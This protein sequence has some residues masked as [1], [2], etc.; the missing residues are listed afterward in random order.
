MSGV[1]YSPTGQGGKFMLEMA[2]RGAAPAFENAWR[3]GMCIQVIASPAE[4]DVDPDAE[5]T[6][7]VKVKHKIEGNDLD[8]PV[9]AKMSS[10]PKSIDPSGQKQKSPATFK[11]KAGPQSGDHGVVSFDSV[12]NRGI[13]GASGNYTVGGGWVISGTGTSNEN[14]QSGVVANNL[15]VSIKDLKVKAE[16]DGALTGTGSMTLSGQV[17]AGGLCKGQLDQTLP[18]TAKGTLVGSSSDGTLKLTLVTPAQPGVMVTMTCQLPGVAYDQAVSAEGYADRYGE[19]LGQI[20]LPAGGGTK[21]ASKTTSFG[22]V[23]DVA[24]S[25]S[26]TVVKAKK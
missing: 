12:S 4:E 3:S 7:T 17:T 14:F 18:I 21:T 6:V 8:K 23:M 26:F 10:G 13:G 20:E 1:D 9:E 15:R 22:G 25:G 2:A 5:V 16:K 19:A 24:A 11:Y